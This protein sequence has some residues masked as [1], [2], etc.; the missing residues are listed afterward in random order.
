MT[1]T[2]PFLKELRILIVDDSAVVR[3]VLSKELLRW[4]I[5]VAQA[6]NGQQALD[7]AL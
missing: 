4:G 5:E 7:I 3:S 6:E 1:E 2:L